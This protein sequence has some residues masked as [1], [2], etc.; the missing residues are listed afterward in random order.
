MDV[1][2]DDILKQKLSMFP[3]PSPTCSLWR[4]ILADR[5]RQQPTNIKAANTPITQEAN[6]FHKSAD[7]SLFIA[8]LGFMGNISGTVGQIVRGAL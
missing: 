3:A 8:A 5:C 2:T 4:L 7:S 6:W 1:S